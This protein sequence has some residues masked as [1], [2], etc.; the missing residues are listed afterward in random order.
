MNFCL[1]VWVAWCEGKP[2]T[3]SAACSQARSPAPCPAPHSARFS[4]SSSSDSAD[5]CARG[6]APPYK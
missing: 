2:S 6:D 3:S 1:C 4:A 5:T